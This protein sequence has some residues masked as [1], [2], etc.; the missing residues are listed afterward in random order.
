[1]L[2]SIGVGA[3]FRTYLYFAS[4]NLY[5]KY[6]AT[7]DD[8]DNIALIKA[9]TELHGPIQLRRLMIIFQSG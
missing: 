3:L 1:M 6:G 2:A 7:V 8:G 5:S 4:E 9:L